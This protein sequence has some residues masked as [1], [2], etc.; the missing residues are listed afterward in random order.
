LGGR[1]EST[2]RS[3]ADQR[4]SP[5]MLARL[6]G[7]NQQKIAIGKWL[8]RY[9]K[10]LI[11]NEP[12]R[13]VDVGTRGENTSFFPSFFWNKSNYETNRICRRPG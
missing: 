10:L 5:L 1:T 12:S 4:V 3:P 13:G 6:S 2:G 9:P 11:L 8:V 7:G